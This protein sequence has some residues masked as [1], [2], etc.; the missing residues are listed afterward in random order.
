MISGAS[1]DTLA[2]GIL[3]GGTAVTVSVSS[4]LVS[5]GF[6]GLML[7]VACFFSRGSSINTENEP[8]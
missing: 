7:P 8:T 2:S 5:S 1:E 3:V 6:T 4:T